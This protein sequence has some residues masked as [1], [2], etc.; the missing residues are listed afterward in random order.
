[1][2]KKLYKSGV[3]KV[4]PS[5]EIDLEPIELESENRGVIHGVVKNTEGK[6][7]VAKLFKFKKG[8]CKDNMLTPVAF[9]YT[10][11]WGQFMFPIIDTDCNTRYIVKV[12]CLEPDD[13]IVDPSIGNC[14]E[15]YE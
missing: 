1:M 7:C 9:Q 15:E 2:G 11:E 10:D 8:Q 3:I 5:Q 4:E 13:C 14:S 12:F 6:I